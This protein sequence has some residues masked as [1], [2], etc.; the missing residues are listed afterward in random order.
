M[1]RLQ[2]IL[3]FIPILL[4]SCE[5]DDSPHDKIP[6]IIVNEFKLTFPEAKDTDW[7]HKPKGYEVDFEKDKLDLT[8]F[9]TSKGEIKKIKYEISENDLP[10]E[11]KTSI[12]QTFQN[13]N[14]DDPERIEE[15]GKIYY[16]VQ[17]EKFLMDE[18]VVLEKSGAIKSN[19]PYWD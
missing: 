17:I 14:I 10:Q 11:V 6:S 19:I 4:V 18:N 13:K 2:A 1:K 8:A 12:S 5:D 15:N 9:F 16:Q 7:N 3:V